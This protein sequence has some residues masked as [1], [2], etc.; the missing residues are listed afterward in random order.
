VGSEGPKM[1]QEAT[2]SYG[3]HRLSTKDSKDENAGVQRLVN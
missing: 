1:L 2:A 3:P